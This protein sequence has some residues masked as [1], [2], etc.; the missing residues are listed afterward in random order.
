MTGKSALDKLR[1]TNR[2]SIR[3]EEAGLI[4]SGIDH[5]RRFLPRGGILHG[6][7]IRLEWDTASRRQPPTSIRTS[8]PTAISP[9]RITRA[10]KPIFPL[11]SLIG[12]P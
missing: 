11:V 7:T 8:S 3:F 4:G 5:V 6:G 1:K 2:N 10:M 9:P 12:L